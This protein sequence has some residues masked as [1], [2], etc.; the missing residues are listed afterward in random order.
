MQYTYNIVEAA[1]L[2]AGV[3]FSVVRER[4]DSA[5]KA[6]IE[7][8]YEEDKRAAFVEDF[9]AEDAWRQ[10]RKACDQCALEAQC[11]EGIV[12]MHYQDGDEVPIL[13]CPQGFPR[14]PADLIPA[15]RIVKKR[16]WTQRLQPHPGEF[17]DLSGFE[18]RL[19]WLQTAL[20][21]GDLDGTPEVVRARDLRDWLRQNFPG[22]L[23]EFLFS[24]E[25]MP[26]QIDG[27]SEKSEHS[28]IVATDK[29]ATPRIVKNKLKN[30]RPDLLVP[31]IEELIEQKGSD[32][33]SKIYPALRTLAGKE[34]APFNAVG[35]RQLENGKMQEILLWTDANGES[36]ELS[37]D[38]LAERLRRR[39][40]GE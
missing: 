40:N 9:E 31:I 37:R 33:A 16:E 17:D 4:M 34:E 5:D 15:P 38:A 25:P 8:K 6:E 19:G 36:Q 39:R 11:P 21:M 10:Q 12:V 32:E 7:A 14:K 26:S 20:N 1:A 2:W 22:Q 29:Y 28:E 13:Q 35:K 30:K 3:D 18:Q 23:P 27:I 24:K